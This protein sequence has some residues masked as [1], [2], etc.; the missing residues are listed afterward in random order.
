MLVGRGPAAALASGCVVSRRWFAAA[1]KAKAVNRVRGTRDLLADDAEQHQAVLDV[2]QRTV[3]RYGFRQVIAMAADAL[4]VLGIKDKVVLELNSLGDNESGKMTLMSPTNAIVPSRVR[5]RVALEAFF[6]QCKD[7]LSADSINRFVS[8]FLLT[9]L[10]RCGNDPVDASRGEVTHSFSR[11][12]GSLERGSVLRILDS[13]S[14]YDQKFVADA[15]RL[16]DFLSDDARTVRSRR[17]SNGCV[18]VKNLEKRQEEEVAMAN[19]DT[20]EFL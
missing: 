17:F 4:D 3:A 11:S 12:F 1:P 9:G 7:E 20:F 18:K 8:V 10:A 6:S 2:L 16:E 5:Y 19:L 13:K 14:E 15:P